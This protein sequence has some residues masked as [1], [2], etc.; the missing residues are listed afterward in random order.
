MQIYNIYITY[1]LYYK[2]IYICAKAPAREG[3]AGSAKTKSAC[4]ARV[5]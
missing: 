1:I 5:S 4:P 2:I 3:S